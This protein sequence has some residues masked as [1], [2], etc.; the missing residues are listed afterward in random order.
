ML[1]LIA[2]KQIARQA[3]SFIN[4]TDGKIGHPDVAGEPAIFH[5]IQSADRIGQWYGFG[6]PVDQCKIEGGNAEPPQACLDRTLQV[7]IGNVRRPDFGGDEDIVAIDTGCAH[8]FANRCLVFLHDSGIH[9]AIT[10]VQ[11]MRDE[12][13]SALAAQGPGAKPNGRDVCAVGG[14]GFHDWFY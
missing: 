7:A 13:R 3:D 1:D 8:A 12:A 6:G 9:M 4:L 2:G 11:G 5:F 10:G 14:D